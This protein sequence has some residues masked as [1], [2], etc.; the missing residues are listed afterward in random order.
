LPLIESDWSWKITSFSLSYLKYWNIV[1]FFYKWNNIVGLK[2]NIASHLD[3]VQDGLY[4][5]NYKLCL[6]HWFNISMVFLPTNNFIIFT[7]L[8]YYYLYLHVCLRAFF[9]INYLIMNKL[10]QLTYDPCKPTPN[11]TEVWNNRR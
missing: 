1:G 11:K 6:Y 2:N 10:N 8:L 7:I 9:F 4:N 5:C 3:K